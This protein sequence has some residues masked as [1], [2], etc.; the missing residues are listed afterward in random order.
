MSRQIGSVKGL[1]GGF[2][3]TVEKV[4]ARLLSCDGWQRRTTSDLAS[5]GRRCEWTSKSQRKHPPTAVIDR[6]RVVNVLRRHLGDSLSTLST[7]QRRVL[8]QLHGCRRGSYGSRCTAAR[9][10]IMGTSR[11]IRVAT[12]IARV[13]ATVAAMVGDC[14]CPKSLWMGRTCMWCLPPRMNSTPCM[15][16]RELVRRCSQTS[17]FQHRLAGPWAE[18]D[19]Q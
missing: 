12:V 7:R 2:G 18:E 13:A 14:G 19:D 10:V 11:S 5:D 17:E 8:Q 9:V 16:C 6:P 1:I 15:T 3:K 4:F